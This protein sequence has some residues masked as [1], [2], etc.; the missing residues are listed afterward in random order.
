LSIPRVVA[1]GNVYLSSNQTYNFAIDALD[2]S[3]YTQMNDCQAA[4][5]AGGNQ[6]SLTVSAC[7]GQVGTARAVLSETCQ[8]RN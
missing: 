7:E 2:A 5:N 4:A 8:S 6:G 3:C 1:S